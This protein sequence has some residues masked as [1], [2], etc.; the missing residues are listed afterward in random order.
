MGLASE[1]TLARS[2]PAGAL[3]RRLLLISPTADDPL[4]DLTVLV[5]DGP[6]RLKIVH[7]GGY[8]GYAEQLAYAFGPDGAVRSVSGPSGISQVPIDAMTALVNDRDQ[9]TVGTTP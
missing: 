8:G 3:G 2:H 4:D 6:D 5:P 7:D 9:V 1:A